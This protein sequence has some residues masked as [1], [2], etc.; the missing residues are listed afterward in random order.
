MVEP[1]AG[2]LENQ[3]A[4]DHFIAHRVKFWM[5]GVLTTI[6]E[7]RFLMESQ[8][9]KILIDYTSMLKTASQKYQIYFDSIIANKVASSGLLDSLSVKLKILLSKYS[10]HV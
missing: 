7:N 4:F 10:R 1:S 2:G 6:L 8:N 5:V 3:T 9:K